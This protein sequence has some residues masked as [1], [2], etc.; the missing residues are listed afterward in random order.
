MRNKGHKTG[1]R[2][3][4]GHAAFL[5]SI[6]EKIF[7]ERETGNNKSIAEAL[8]SIGNVLSEIANH[9]LAQ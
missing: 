2:F 7:A 4:H 1:C 6:D 8:R 3:L 5:Q 9:E